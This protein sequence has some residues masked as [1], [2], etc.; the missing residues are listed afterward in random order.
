MKR[1]LAILPLSRYLA[2]KRP[3]AIV[4]ALDCQNI[5]AIIA[6][7]VA[8]ID[9]RVIIG[10]RDTM[11]EIS[12]WFIKS[13]ARLVFPYAEQVVAVSKGV[14]EDLIRI[15]P[16]VRGKTVVIYN[17]VDIKKIE[18]L[19]NEEPE[20]KWF[21][22]G[23]HQIILGAGEFRPCKDFP[24]LIRAFKEV[25]KK[26]QVKLIILGD[27][28]E[29]RKLESL[30]SELDLNE[31][32]SLPGSTKNPFA[33]MSRAS[34]FVL[35]SWGGE[36]FG[37]VILESLACGCPVVSTDCKSGPSE[38]LAG[39]KWGE[40]VKVGDVDGMARAIE[41]TLDNPMPKDVLKKRASDFSIENAVNSYL[42][43]VLGVGG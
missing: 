23:G 37:N 19:A 12:N 42:R 30:I 34:V 24:L 39:G 14:A 17:P 29:R 8:G 20:H 25:R 9:C 1:F 32:I 31:D 35:S 11:S 27:G 3:D 41:R 33:Y 16:R 4:S 15:I 6:K 36:G 28:K 7:Y 26:R 18:R 10:Q 40:L 21:K 2:Q 43:I 13:L 38:I 22:E 5:I